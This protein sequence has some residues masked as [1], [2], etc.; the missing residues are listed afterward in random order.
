M[1]DTDT[2]I[3]LIKKKPPSVIEK[4]RACQ[5]GD[6]GISA[7]TVAELRYGASKSQRI[8][9]NHEALDL[10]LAPFEVVTFDETAAA[11]YGGIRAQLEKAGQPIGPLD[12]LI[13]AHAK[14]MNAALVTNNVGEFK[15]IKGLKVETW[16]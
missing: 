14:G 4:L 13:A 3:Y 2:C 15:R 10:F 11:A 5:A 9:Q 7:V 8:Q 6:V 1:L 16:I 12:M